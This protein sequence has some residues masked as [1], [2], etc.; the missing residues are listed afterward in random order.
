MA[1]NVDGENDGDEI[2]KGTDPNVPSVDS[3]GDGII[4][5]DEIE[6]H[7]TDPE[8]RDTDRDSMDDG[9]ELNEGFDPLN[10]EDCPDWLCP[11]G[12]GWRWRVMPQG[13]ELTTENSVNH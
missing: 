8:N 6:I 5:F 2:K 1:A 7:K 10:S 3:D 9:F 4:D 12:R 11:I 13:S